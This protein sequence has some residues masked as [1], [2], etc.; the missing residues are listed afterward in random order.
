MAWFVQLNG[1]I[2]GPLQDDQLRQLASAGK[3][4]RDTEVSQQRE[5]PWVAA[6]RIKNLFPEPAPTAPPPAQVETQNL[7]DHREDFDD[8]PSASRAN[9]SE[10][11]A[12]QRSSPHESHETARGGSAA[13]L[14][15]LTRIDQSIGEA[16]D[17]LR[18]LRQS[19]P[20][21]GL[22]NVS[23]Y[24]VGDW[25]GIIFRAAVALI[26]LQILLII[27]GVMIFA[28]ISDMARSR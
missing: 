10:P 28:V 2:F 18:S 13:E 19:V 5:G 24:G 25:I 27:V 21:S 17:L 1:K 22:R 23:D 7:E 9:A 3:I 4:F 15:A 14:A 26:I 11:P 8:P 20:Q 16:V 12:L 6:S